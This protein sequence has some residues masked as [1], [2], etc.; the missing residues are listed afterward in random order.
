MVRRA[1]RMRSRWGTLEQ[2][3]GRP[4]FCTGHGPCMRVLVA[5]DSVLM[6]HLLDRYLASWGYE[7]V[8]AR[9]GL[10]A[11]AILCQPSA[12]R[13][14]IIDWTMPRMDGPSLCR[15]LRRRESSAH[16]HVI[17]L[18]GKDS[19]HDAAAALAAGADD[20][21]LKP[22]DPEVLRARLRVAARRVATPSSPAVEPT[23]LPE[24][25]GAGNP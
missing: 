18:T 5:E 7:A 15:H 2:G 19:P 13:L 21:L 14:A 3:R 16:V 11:L 17:L 25:G 23:P 8:I 9:D 1:M 6:A 22:F 10:Q 12:P 4:A 20:F 24:A